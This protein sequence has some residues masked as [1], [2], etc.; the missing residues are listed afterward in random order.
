MWNN[1]TEVSIYVKDISIFSFNYVNWTAIGRP[2]SHV[3][4]TGNES[5][6]A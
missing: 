1:I 5:T 3:N 4:L 6:Q 2:H